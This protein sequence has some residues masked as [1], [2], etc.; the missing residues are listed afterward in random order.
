VL[1]ER[2][3]SVLA[4]SRFQRTL[5]E[6]P[7]GTGRPGEA[8]PG[9]RGGEWE[10]PGASAPPPPAI[11]LPLPAGT[12]LSHLV[13]YVI[14]FVLFVLLVLWL[15]RFVRER[16]GRPDRASGALPEA[17]RA[18]REPPLPDAAAL[19]E[20]GRY[21]EAVHALLLQAIARLAERTRTPL[22]PSRT[23][24]EI[25]RL[26][27]LREDVRRPF[28]ELVRAVEVSLFGGAPVGPDDYRRSLE[29]YRSVFGGSG[30][31][32]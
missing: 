3:R 4:D 14:L 15:A 25:A 8:W 19:A 22:P 13:L 31:S 23:S 11:E 10:V 26:L 12:A 27:P 32:A 9:R 21:A 17:S 28:A 18:R 29:I 7:E 1:R 2:A 20:A 24:R 5:P 30:G 6:S 16:W